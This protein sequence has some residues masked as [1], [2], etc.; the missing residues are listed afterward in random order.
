MTTL[1]M[2]LGTSSHGRKVTLMQMALPKEIENWLRE[3][4][5]GG[6][7][8]IEAIVEELVVAQRLAELDIEHDDHAWAKPAV[9]DALKSLGEGRGAPLAEVVERL[10]AE[11]ARRSKP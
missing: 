6:Q 10:R 2:M 11:L 3:R 8:S 7:S 4:A 9:D 1:S 5:V